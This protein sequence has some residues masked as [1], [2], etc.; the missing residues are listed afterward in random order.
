MRE[1][2]NGFV[3]YDSAMVE[4]FLEFG[5]GFGTLMGGQ[6]GFSANVDGV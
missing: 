4:D 1:C 5:G 2:S 6:I 3:A